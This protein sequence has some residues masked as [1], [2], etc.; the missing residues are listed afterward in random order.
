MTAH[1]DSIATVSR[2]PRL[3]MRLAAGA[4]ALLV[5]AGALGYV[6]GQSSHNREFT[7]G[8]GLVITSSTGGT[9]YLGANQRPDRPPKGFAYV[10]PAYVPWVDAN[11]TVHE[12]GERPPCLRHDRTAR[13]PEMEVVTFPIAGAY[14]GTVL[15][16]R[17]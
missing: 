14:Q 17:C 2:V 5:A 11:G 4:A 7:T 13:V 15:W 8:P 9:A 6:L 10:V 16:I 12:G 1:P 3:R